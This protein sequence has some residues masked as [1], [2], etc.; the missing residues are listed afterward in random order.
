VLNQAEIDSLLG[1]DEGPAGGENRTGMPLL[2]GSLN[3]D[4]PNVVS[5]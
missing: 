1:F 5:G 3:W 4:F 2:S